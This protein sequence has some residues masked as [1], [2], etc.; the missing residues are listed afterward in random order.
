VGYVWRLYRTGG[1]LISGVQLP[2]GLI[3][4]DLLPEPI[5][6]PTTK[7]VIGHDVEITEREIVEAGLV[8]APQWEK[9]SPVCPPAL[10][11]RGGNGRKGRHAPM[12]CQV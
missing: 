12:R 11:A 2:D 1:R 5:I 4:N 7:S 6:T 10:S 9:N 8:P 3:E